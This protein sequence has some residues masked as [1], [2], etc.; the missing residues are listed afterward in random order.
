MAENNEE[1]KIIVDEDWKS[2]AKSE[3]EELKKISITFLIPV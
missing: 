3:K 2:Q 1:K